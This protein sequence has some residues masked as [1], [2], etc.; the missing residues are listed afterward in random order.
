MQFGQMKCE[1]LL[2]DAV[3]KKSSLYDLRLVQALVLRK[4]P[5]TTGKWMLVLQVNKK[6]IDV[7]YL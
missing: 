6:N 1:I 4:Q 3:I 2:P 7:K 5:T